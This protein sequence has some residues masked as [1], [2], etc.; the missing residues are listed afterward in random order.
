VNVWFLNEFQRILSSWDIVKSSHLNAQSLG[1]FVPYAHEADS[2]QLKEGLKQSG[3]S[4]AGSQNHNVDVRTNGRH[5][6]ISQPGV[7]GG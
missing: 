4:F 3:S 7:Y 6:M 1:V 5:G 2:R